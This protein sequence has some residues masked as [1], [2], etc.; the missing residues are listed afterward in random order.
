L[1]DFEVTVGCGRD[2]CLAPVGLLV[3]REPGGVFEDVV[4]GE[5]WSAD[6]DC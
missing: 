4:G 5:E 1:G 2:A 6:M 3:Q